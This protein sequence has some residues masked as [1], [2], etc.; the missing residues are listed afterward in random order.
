V[1]VLDGL[2][3]NTRLMVED[4]PTREANGGYCSEQEASEGVDHPTLSFLALSDAD[5][6]YA[7]EHRGI[8]TLAALDGAGV[9][10]L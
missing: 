9:I 5:L 8:H 10:R 4:Q 3:K 6:R 1:R 2:S 7:R